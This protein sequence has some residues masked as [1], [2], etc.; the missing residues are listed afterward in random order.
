VWRRTIGPEDC[1]FGAHICRT[2]TN[3]AYLL[4]GENAQNYSA[5]QSR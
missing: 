4:L 5:Q 2:K 3:V 1:G